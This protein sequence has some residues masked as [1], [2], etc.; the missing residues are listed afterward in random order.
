MNKLNIVMVSGHGCIRCQKEAIPL[1]QAGHTVHMIARKVPSFADQYAS[2]TIC[3]NVEQYREAVRVYA[4]VADV[5][6]IQNEPSWYGLL[7]KEM[8]DKPVVMDVHDTFLTRSTPDED[9]Q[10]RQSGGRHVRITCEERTAF[11]SAD[12]LVFVSDTV[13][14]DVVGEFKLNQPSIVLPSYVPIGLYK[15]QFGEW[16]GDLVYEGKVTLPEENREV[17]ATGFYYCDYMDLAKQTVDAGIT[18]HLYPGRTDEEFMKAYKDLAAVHEPLPYAKLLQ[19]ISRHDWGVVGNTVDSPQWQKTLPNKLYDYVASGVPIVAFNASESSKVL[20]EYGI[21]ITVSS[22]E[23]L[24]GRWREHRTCRDRLIKVRGQLSM[25]AHIG[26]LLDLY[27][28]LI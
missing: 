13:R 9:E 18:F 3:A 19:A 20:E 17:G 23:E 16:L 27:R 14:D 2:L 25:E 26:R 12:A 11:Q 7:V 6:H 1:I 22:I 21:G 10:Q 8:C 15:Y 5:F 4:N 24:A 28:Q